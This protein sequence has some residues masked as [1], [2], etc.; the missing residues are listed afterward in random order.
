MKLLELLPGGAGYAPNAALSVLFTGVSVLL[1]AVFGLVLQYAPLRQ[2]LRVRPRTAL[3]LNAG[4][5]VLCVP[6]FLAYPSLLSGAEASQFTGLVMWCVLFLPLAF[7]LLKG[8]AL[9]NLFAVPY[10]LCLS[11]FVLG[12][13]NWLAFQL[14]GVFPPESSALVAA[15]ARLLLFSVFL[16]LGVRS[17]KKLFAAWGAGETAPFW[18]VMWLLPVALFVLTMLSGNVWTLTGS[19]STAFLLTRVLC[20]AALLTCVAMMTGIM[21]RE[22]EIA[23]ERAREQMMD[24]LGEARDKSRAETLAAWEKTIAARQKTR[25]AIEGILVCSQAGDQAGIA[26]ILQEMMSGLTDATVER[27]CENE[28]VDALVAHYAA[29]ACREGIETSFQLHIPKRAG[30][31]QNVDLSRIVGN[32]LENAAEAC[33]RMDYGARFI[34]LKSMISQDMLVLVM[35]NSFDGDFTELP[36]GRYLSRRR[37]SGVATGLSSIQTT[38]RKYN[39]SALFETDGRVF[40]TSVRLDMGGQVM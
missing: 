25:A 15:A 13:G 28:A 27:F 38:A 9:Q 18:K 19:N 36:D 32:M 23:V 3:L 4:L 39:G 40:K 31:L 8:C 17:L 26:A 16:P 35:D 12:V 5:L 2:F 33:L 10:I 29:L 21:D 7:Y 34:R 20:V 22:R 1:N 24:V 14:E 6:V 11:S 37:K 30:Q